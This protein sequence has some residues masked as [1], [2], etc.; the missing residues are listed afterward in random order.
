MSLDVEVKDE[1]GPFCNALR[2]E[3]RKDMPVVTQRAARMLQTKIEREIDKWAENPTGNLAKSFAI[4]TRARGGNVTASVQS[5]APYAY[6]HETGGIIRPRNGKYLTIPMTPEARARPARAWGGRLFVPRGKR[7]LASKQGRGIKP[8]F[9]L[10]KQSRI[11]PKR[12][13]SKAVKG[14]QRALLNLF[15]DHLEVQVK[16]AAQKARRP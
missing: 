10:V 3:I 4:V 1:L 11:R 7:Y 13:L 5:D 8:Q 15:G 12:Y 6:I 9:A 2:R 16:R 14:S